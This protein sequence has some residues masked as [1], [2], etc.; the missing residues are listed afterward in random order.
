MQSTLTFVSPDFHW[1]PPNV[2]QPTLFG[3]GYLC[4]LA[5][6]IHPALVPDV[7]HPAQATR[8]GLTVKR[9]HR[10]Y[11]CGVD[12]IFCVWHNAHVMGITSSVYLVIC[13]CFVL[14]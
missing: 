7:H 5:R 3:S 9:V 14:S 10:Q 6:N 13:S 12:P 4:D 8:P 1:N 2:E 11:S